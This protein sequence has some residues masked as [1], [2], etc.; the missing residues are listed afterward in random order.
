MAHLE[1]EKLKHARVETHPFNYTIVPGFLRP[2]SVKQINATYPKI[3]KGGS[4]PIESLDAGM[5]IKEVID[6]LNGPEFEKVIA[7]KFGREC[8]ALHFS[9]IH[10]SIIFFEQRPAFIR[11]ATD[12]IHQRR[13]NG[14]LQWR[15]HQTRCRFTCRSKAQSMQYRVA[16]IRW[17][18]CSHEPFGVHAR[19]LFG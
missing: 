19:P 11:R 16:P 13:Q 12:M 5:T 4:Y 2:E 8:F 15:A 10:H 18:P 14:H 17:I 9:F 3:D 6:E 7:E 1:L